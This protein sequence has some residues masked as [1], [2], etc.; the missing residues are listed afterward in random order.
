MQKRVKRSRPVKAMAAA[1]GGARPT[2]TT[3]LSR[4]PAT[5]TTATARPSSTS[6]VTGPGT[7]IAPNTLSI[8]RPGRG[9]AKHGRPACR[10]RQC[11][12]RH[13]PM[14]RRRAAGQTREARN[15]PAHTPGRRGPATLQPRSRQQ[16][17]TAPNCLRRGPHSVLTVPVYRG[18]PYVARPIPHFARV[19][20]VPTVGH[21]AAGHVAIGSRVADSDAHNCTPIPDTPTRP[22]YSGAPSW[23]SSTEAVIDAPTRSHD[24]TSSRLRS[25]GPDT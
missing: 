14:P 19:R 4:E 16:R 5:A 3:S 18:M 8:W 22:R 2:G 10:A 7:G 12:T 23:H 1:R 9:K 25:I 17:A 13:P 20:I 11:Q 21:N 24:N 6:A 15:A